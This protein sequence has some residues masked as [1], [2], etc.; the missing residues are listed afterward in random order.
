MIVRSWRQDDDNAKLKTP[1]QIFLSYL[2]R[3]IPVFSV[4]HYKRVLS[5]LIDFVFISAPTSSFNDKNLSSVVYL[6]HKC[7]FR[8]FQT[9]L[10]QHIFALFCQTPSTPSYFF[11]NSTQFSAVNRRHFIFL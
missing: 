7:Y 5:K 3:T 2:I 4:Q 1:M 9:L 11:S 8:C 10:V 6:L